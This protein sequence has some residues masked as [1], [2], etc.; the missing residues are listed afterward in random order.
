MNSGTVSGE[1]RRG[2]SW[3]PGQYLEIYGEQIASGM[4]QEAVQI[5]VAREGQNLSVLRKALPRLS[6]RH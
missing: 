5:Y 4:R 3:D 1:I 6:V 2:D